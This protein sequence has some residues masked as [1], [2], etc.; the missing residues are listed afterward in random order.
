MPTML[1]LHLADFC[2]AGLRAVAIAVVVALAPRGD[3]RADPPA[4]PVLVELFTSQGCSSCPP[5]DAFLADLAERPDV[6]ALSYHVDYWNYIGWA[7]PFSSP[8]ATERQ[9]AY[10]KTLGSPVVYTPQMVIDG[11]RDA[12]GSHRAT[13]EQAIA[14]ASSVRRVALTITGDAASGYRVAL[15]ATALDATAGIR[16]VLYDRRHETTVTRGENIGRTIENRN[17]VRAIVELAAW[18]GAATEIPLALDPAL[19]AGHDGC[20]VI[21]QQ[22]EA[23]P[24]LGVA[25]IELN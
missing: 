1:R 8:E 21:V 5:A 13:V 2:T 19:T 16:L 3:A 15:P 14:A 22:G 7:D 24:V 18:D 10:G 9:R 11:R 12:V 23:G 20:A 17:V 4:Q 6:L 25:A